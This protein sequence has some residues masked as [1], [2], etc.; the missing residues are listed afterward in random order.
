MSSAVEML[1][2]C[3]AGQRAPRMFVVAVAPMPPSMHVGEVDFLS[4]FQCA[5]ALDTTDHD[6]LRARLH[7]A[8][9]A[10]IYAMTEIP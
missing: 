2:Q 9:D 5:V 3:S 10:I 1:A 8:I 7:D 4:G 6:E